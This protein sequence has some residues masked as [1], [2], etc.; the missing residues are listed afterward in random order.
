MFK[1]KKDTFKYFDEIHITNY[2]KDTFEG[3]PDNTE[4]IVFIREYL[5]DLPISIYSTGSVVH[6]T[7]E[8][9]R[10]DN[11]CFRLTSET[12]EFVDGFIYPCCAGSGLTTKVRIP[13]Q[14][15]WKQEVTKLYPPCHECVFGEP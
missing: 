14:D 6:M 12:V 3:S 13:L 5:K 2:T 15:N 9:K 1:K 11:P 4:D 10:G 8:T 7:P